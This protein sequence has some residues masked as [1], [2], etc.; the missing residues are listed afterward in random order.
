MI[1]LCVGRKTR[2][3]RTKAYMYNAFLLQSS[4]S[5]PKRL[6]YNHLANTQFMFFCSWNLDTQSHLSSSHASPLSSRPVTHSIGRKLALFQS[7]GGEDSM[8]IF[9]SY[10][11]GC[12]ELWSRE[13]GTRKNQRRL[14]SLVLHAPERSSCTINSFCLLAE[15][16]SDICKSRDFSVWR[17]TSSI[18]TV[19]IIYNVE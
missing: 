9:D 16:L 3:I 14:S 8:W 10:F 15:I 19:K 6:K 11:K 12:V 5:S 7:L 4:K 17:K 1:Y 2:P 13:R 18:Q